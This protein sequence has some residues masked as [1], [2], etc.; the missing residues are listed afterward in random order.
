MQDPGECRGEEPVDAIVEAERRAD[1]QELGERPRMEAQR[2][3]DRD[4]LGRR[5]GI[6]RMQA[7]AGRRDAGAI[8]PR[9]A[10]DLERQP[11]PGV[12][13]TGPGQSQAGQARSRLGLRRGFHLR[14]REQVGERVEIV[15]DADPALGAGLQRG[16][17]AA[18]ERVED[19]VAGP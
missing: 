17:A 15:A 1:E 19:H 13:V 18:A 4:R 11:V 14:R 12:R 6:A 5:R 9:I 2:D 16:R 8:D 10:E 7:A 3:L